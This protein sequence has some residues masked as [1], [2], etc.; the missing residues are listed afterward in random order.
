MMNVGANA[1]G[2][3][4]TRTVKK[5]MKDVPLLLEQN[6]VRTK[7]KTSPSEEFRKSKQIDMTEKKDTKIQEEKDVKEDSKKEQKEKEQDEQIR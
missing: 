7:S 1:I 6:E 3:E 2:I 5:L 4:K